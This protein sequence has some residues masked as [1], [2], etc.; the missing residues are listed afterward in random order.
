[1]TYFACIFQ[2]IRHSITAENLKTAMRNIQQA[3]NA[4]RTAKPE[5]FLRFR[6]SVFILPIHRSHYLRL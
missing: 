4:K 2:M 6:G 5:F 3:Y 1:M